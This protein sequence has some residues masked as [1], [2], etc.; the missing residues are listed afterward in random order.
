MDPLD[1][2]GTLTSFLRISYQ[3][4]PL[5]PGWKG[6]E[7]EWNETKEKNDTVGGS[8][9]VASGAQRAKQDCSLT[10]KPNGTYPAELWIYFRPVIF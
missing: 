6:I 8:K 4:Q 1:I 3:Q 2:Q 5:Q 10:L 9:A 7:I